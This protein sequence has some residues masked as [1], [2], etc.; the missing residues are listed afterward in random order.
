M[1]LNTRFAPL[2]ILA[3]AGAI[4]GLAWAGTHFSTLTADFVA[5]LDGGS[6]FNVS[7]TTDELSLTAVDEILGTDFYRG[8]ANF[9]QI[10]WWIE[11][12]K[13]DGTF[14]DQD[15]PCL[16]TT[17]VAGFYDDTT[18]YTANVGTY[19]IGPHDGVTAQASTSS[20][21]NF[22]S[23]DWTG[24][25]NYRASELRFLSSGSHSNA[26]APAVSTYDLTIDYAPLGAGGSDI[27]FSVTVP[28]DSIAT[29]LPGAVVAD[30]DNDGLCE[31]GA[32]DEWCITETGDAVGSATI[33][34]D[35]DD[36]D[37]GH[38]WEIQVFLENEEI[39]DID[40][41]YTLFDPLTAES[42]GLGGPLAITTVVTQ[43]TYSAHASAFGM[44]DFEGEYVTLANS[45]DA[46]DNAL[47]W[48]LEYNQTL[49]DGEI[50]VDFD[51]DEANGGFQAVNWNN[52][53]A[54]P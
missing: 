10:E 8:S 2:A 44:F 27:A 24:N 15:H 14:F 26:A 23:A 20:S 32:D 49:N 39:E 53:G 31:L 18:H 45:I 43:A 25:T 22:L 46:G 30:D 36:D 29:G 3:A 42:D 48:Q 28:L 21:L 40:I 38:L 47:W 51:C 12:E 34:C 33:S 50:R 7:T 9:D 35:T 17:D 11:H 6:T 52:G 5:T 37:V 1:R 54:F 19:R 16:D 41:A 13:D 4:G